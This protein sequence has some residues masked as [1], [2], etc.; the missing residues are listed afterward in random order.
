MTFDRKKYLTEIVLPNATKLGRF[1]K[2]LTFLRCDDSDGKIGEQFASSVVFVN[3]V[4]GADE[5]GAK[6]DSERSFKLVLKFM[7][8]NVKIREIMN[9]AAQFHNEIVMYT[10][11]LPF[12]NYK[13]IVETHF[14]QFYY[15]NLAKGE[16]SQ[17][18]IVVIE[19]LRSKN[20]GLSKHRLFFD[21]DHVILLLQALGRF[22]ALSYIAKQQKPVE[23]NNIKDKLVEHVWNR[24]DGTLSAGMIIGP[25]AL[26]GVRAFRESKDN[27]K[28]EKLTNKLENDALGLMNYFVT[29]E[30]PLSVVCH[31]DFCN[32]NS[33][34]QY[35]DD[36]DT[37]VSVRMIDLQ[38][39][40]YA[41]PVIDLAMILYLNTNDELRANH[42]DTFLKSYHQSVSDTVKSA[43]C[44]PPT[45]EQLENEVKKKIFYGY[46][47][48]SY[49][50]PMMVNQVRPN[51]D[52][53]ADGNLEELMQQMLH[54]GGETGTQLLISIL[55]HMLQHEY[56]SF[57]T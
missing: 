2:G 42:W 45:F 9:S 21:Y 29:P 46:F 43:G 1:G 31:G 30:E 40:R 55:E 25:S 20:F 51:M 16:E 39:S 14:P 19:D 13:D 22:H 6:G 5:A 37:P 27:E 17:E 44:I 24:N 49:F 8:E 47:H 10:D 36:S 33:L 34:F 32:H 57:L 26:R 7:P 3:A 35:Q 38:T 54:M 41:S 11:I 15:G 23:F 28:L 56:F 18:T 4:F 53:I 50:L 12:L 52:E 48:C